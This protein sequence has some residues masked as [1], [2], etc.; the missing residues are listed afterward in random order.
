MQEFE[1]AL[2]GWAYE[3]GEQNQGRAAKLLGIPRS[4]FQYRWSAAFGAQSTPEAAA[5]ETEPRA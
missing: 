4:T 3:K 2:L 1:R 5:P